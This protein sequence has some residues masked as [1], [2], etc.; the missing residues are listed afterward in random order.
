MKY[1]VKYEDTVIGEYIVEEINTEYI[2]M[3]DAINNLKEKGIDVLPMI[4]HSIKGPIPFFDNRIKNCSR[5]P[6]KKISYHTDSVEL[7]PK[8]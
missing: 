4:N 2:V 5:F 7:I 3:A 8:D 1:I 6:G